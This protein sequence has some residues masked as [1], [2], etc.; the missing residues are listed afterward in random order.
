MQ[1]HF[2][3]IVHCYEDDFYE[4][5]YTEILCENGQF[6]SPQKVMNDPKFTP[7]LFL[8]RKSARQAKKV[9]GHWPEYKILKVEDP[10]WLN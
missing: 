8:S 5:K 10:S 7:I 9:F 4:R 3:V 1:Q 2:Y 6:V